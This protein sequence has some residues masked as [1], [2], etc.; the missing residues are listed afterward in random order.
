MS[1]INDDERLLGVGALLVWMDPV[2][3]DDH[4]TPPPPCPLHVLEDTVEEGC[5]TLAPLLGNRVI[6]CDDE[7]ILDVLLVEQELCCSQS[8]RGLTGTDWVPQDLDLAWRADEPPSRISGLFGLATDL[9]VSDRCSEVVSQLRKEALGVR[10]PNGHAQSSS[11]E[12][13]ASSKAGTAAV[14]S[15]SSGSWDLVDRVSASGR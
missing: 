6:G 4:P 2:G 10:P 13:N 9:V 1:L 12:R 8:H 15:V 11:A 14:S 7:Q 3:A 5:G